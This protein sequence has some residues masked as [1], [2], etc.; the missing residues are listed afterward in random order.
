MRWPSLAANACYWAIARASLVNGRPD[1]VFMLRGR[2]KNL[3][4]HRSY[5]SGSGS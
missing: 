2:V 3:D 5:L 4:L 1:N